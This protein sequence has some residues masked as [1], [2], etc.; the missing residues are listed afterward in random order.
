MQLV[1]VYLE[2]VILGMI[3][4]GGFVIG[5]SII[6]FI[7]KSGKEFAKGFKIPTAGPKLQEMIDAEDFPEVFTVVTREDG[8]EV[9]IDEEGEILAERKKN[10]VWSDEWMRD[11]LNKN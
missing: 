8:T 10:N 1:S 7:I 6:K 4:G 2:I 5:E 9:A 3:L 11:F